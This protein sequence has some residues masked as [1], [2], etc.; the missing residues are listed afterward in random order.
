[1]FP[2]RN[3]HDDPIEAEF[4]FPVHDKSAV[5]KFEAD[6]NGRTIIAEIQE[7]EKVTNIIK[8]Y[9]IMS[10]FGNRYT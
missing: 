10:C 5:Y 1:M 3:D 2:C 8:I 7:K 6:I 4:I 9:K